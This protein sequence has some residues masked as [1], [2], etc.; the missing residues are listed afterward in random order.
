MALIT[1]QQWGAAPYRRGGNVWSGPNRGVTVHYL[2]PRVGTWPHTSCASRV[3]AI[4]RF[5]QG[6]RGWTDI[7]YNLLACPH[8]WLFEGRGRYRANGANGDHSNKSRYSICAM[9]GAG[10]P[11]P[12]AMLDGITQ[13][14]ALCRSWGA[15]ASVDGHR[16]HQSTACPGDPLYRLI[17]AGRFEPGRTTTTDWSDMATKEEIKAAIREVLA[18]EATARAILTGHRIMVDPTDPAG[19]RVAPSRVI[20]LGAA[21]AV[22]AAERAGVNVTAIRDAIAAAVDDIDITATIKE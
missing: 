1:R 15:G 8:G 10:D 18:E 19:Q 9:V 13:G 7:A 3:R 2:G 22:R 6:V 17:R 12:E 14:V 4:Q 5:H 16:D 11:I 20:E 21:S